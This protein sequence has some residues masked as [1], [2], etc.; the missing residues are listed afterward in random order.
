MRLKETS[1]MRVRRGTYCQILRLVKKSQCFP[2]N[3]NQRQMLIYFQFLTVELEIRRGFLYLHQIL[4]FNFYMNVTIGAQMILSRYALRYFT[5]FTLSMV[6]N[7]EE[8]FHV[9]LGYYLIKPRRLTPGFLDNFS[10]D[11]KTQKTEILMI[12]LMTLRELQSVPSTTSIHK[13]K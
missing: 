7:A 3:I 5:R 6:N 1:A 4:A 11:W 12:F 13:L 9:F 2:R 8:T 10:F